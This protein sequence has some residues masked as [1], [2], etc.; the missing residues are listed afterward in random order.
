MI[1]FHFGAVEMPTGF[2][3]G[4]IS[5]PELFSRSWVYVFHPAM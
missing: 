1:A 4:L 5:G 3:G 2:I